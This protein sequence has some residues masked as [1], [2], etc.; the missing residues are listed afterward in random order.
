VLAGK[1]AAEVV[2]ERAAGRAFSAEP[3]PVQASVEARAREARPRD[4]VGVLGQGPSLLGYENE[5]L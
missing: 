2:C 4:P 3:R 5:T 1:L